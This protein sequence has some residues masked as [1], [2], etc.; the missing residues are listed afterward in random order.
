MNIITQIPHFI[1]NDG[2]SW[3]QYIQCDYCGDVLCSSESIFGE[4]FLH[5][6]MTCPNCGEIYLSETHLQYHH[7]DYGSESK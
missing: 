7:D 4:P 1:D 5:L 6:I 2:S 3:T